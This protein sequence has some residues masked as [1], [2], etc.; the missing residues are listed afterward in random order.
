[1]TTFYCSNRSTVY[2][3]RPAAAFPLHINNAAP[4]P[5]AFP[6]PELLCDG[7]RDEGQ[8][9][10]QA[11]IDARARGGAAARGSEGA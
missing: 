7:M 2:A 4:G 11:S 10:G 8:G 9:Q 5:C 1:M 6:Q 3:P